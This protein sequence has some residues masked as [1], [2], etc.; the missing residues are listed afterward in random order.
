M[1][2]GYCVK[3][4]TPLRKIIAMRMSQ[5]KQQIPHYR[6]AVDIEMDSVFAIRQRLN[7][8]TPNQKLSV[9]DFVIKAC[10]TA[11]MEVPGLNV[12]VMESEIHYYREANISIVVAVEGGLSTPVL[13][14]AN[15]KT[16]WEVSAEARDLAERAVAGHLKMSDIS[17]GSFSISNLGMYDV[18]QFDAIINPPQGAILAVGAAKLQPLVRGNDINLANMMRVT[19]SAD[20][21]A[22]DGTDSAQFLSVLKSLLQHPEELVNEV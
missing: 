15:K 16:V 10:A 2:D 17:G 5:A 12:Q 7:T 13:R 1:N 14:H 4:L 18:D 21:R 9:N 20:H 22:I 8:E 19:L 6:V 3:P 11:L